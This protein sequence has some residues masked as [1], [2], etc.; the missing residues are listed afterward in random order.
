[1]N[2]LPVHASFRTSSWKITRFFQLFVI[3]L[4]LKPRWKELLLPIEA[5]LRMVLQK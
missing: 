3:D 4:F 2:Q 5:R 1:L